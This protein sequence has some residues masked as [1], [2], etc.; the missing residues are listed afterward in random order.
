[1]SAQLD[2]LLPREITCFMCFS[3]NG[4]TRCFDKYGRPYYKC[5]MCSARIWLANEAHCFAVAALANALKDKNA[6][7]V[8]RNFVQQRKS[9]CI[10]S[11]LDVRALIRANKPQPV[12]Q[13]AA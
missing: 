2:A 1:M 10:A 11:G 6:L 7:S 8:L 9:A 12:E 4:M 3:D 13:G 5:C